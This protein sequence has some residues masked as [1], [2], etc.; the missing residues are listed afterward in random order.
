[1]AGKGRESNGDEPSRVPTNFFLTVEFFENVES[2]ASVSLDVNM[3]SKLDEA[4]YKTIISVFRRRA[5]TTRA[6]NALDD[7]STKAKRFLA[8]LNKVE[9]AFPGLLEDV[10]DHVVDDK[11]DQILPWISPQRRDLLDHDVWSGVVAAVL[12]VAMGSQRKSTNIR[13]RI[14][15]RKQGKSRHVEVDALIRTAIRVYQNGGGGR[16][17][18][19]GSLKGPLARFLT[20]FYNYFPQMIRPE[21]AQTAEAFVERAREIVNGG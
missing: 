8:A 21:I 1:M 20:E 16:P 19:G 15:K 13:Q 11:P 17:A 6:A 3:R 12:I 10:V 7:L 5:T 9:R 14:P 4:Y 2:V 18:I